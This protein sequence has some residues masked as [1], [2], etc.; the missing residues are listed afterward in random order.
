MFQWK[1]FVHPDNYFLES[2][3]EDVLLACTCVILA[4]RTYLPI[5]QAVGYDDNNPTQKRYG[6]D[7]LKKHKI[8]YLVKHGVS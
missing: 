5:W 6:M 7:N 2:T 4:T 8:V 3:F 1:T